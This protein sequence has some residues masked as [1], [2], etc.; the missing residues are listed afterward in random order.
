[1]GSV[2]LDDLKRLFALGKVPGFVVAK[3]ESEGID[4]AKA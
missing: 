4:I 2:A 1:M 3:L